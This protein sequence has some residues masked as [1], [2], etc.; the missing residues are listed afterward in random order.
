VV[1]TAVGAVFAVAGATVALAARV[2]VINKDVACMVRLEAID[3]A[4]GIINTGA[5]RV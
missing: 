3:R 2:P 4:R 1:A 5:R